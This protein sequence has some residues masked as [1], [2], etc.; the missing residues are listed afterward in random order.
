[1]STDNSVDIIKEYLSWN[2][3]LIELKEKRYNGGTRNVGVEH[4]T[5][6]YILFLDCD[7][8]LVDRNVLKE[9]N[10]TIL[11][12]PN[13]DLVRLSYVAHK[14]R[15]ARVKIRDN[16]LKDLANSVF[17]APWTKMVKREKF[18]PFPENTLLEDVVQH[19]AQIDNIDTM[20]NHFN[21]WAVWN[22][23]NEDAISSDVAKYTEES[24][25]FSSVY[26]NYADLLDLKCKHDYCE[27]QRQFRL[28]NYKDIILRDDV[29]NLI[30][31]GSSQ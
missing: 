22:R 31:G 26:R 8:W 29:L 25:R 9:I 5:G 17:C 13:V 18:V 3:W 11:L 10:R 16:N 7:D 23:E 30:N 4:A 1:M 12:N 20:V 2:V 28:R 27:E 14:G 6:D 24:K 21:Y 15:D 19:I